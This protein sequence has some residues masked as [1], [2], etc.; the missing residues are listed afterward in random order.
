MEEVCRFND[1]SG[2]S[3]VRAVPRPPHRH[4]LA[5]ENRKHRG[6]TEVVM[7]LCLDSSDLS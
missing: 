6:N 4:T 5:G 1:E 2:A 3:R 7:M